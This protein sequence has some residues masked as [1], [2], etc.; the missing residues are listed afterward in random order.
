MRFVREGGWRCAPV[1][2]A[3]ADCT[4]GAPEDSHDDDYEAH[5]DIVGGEEKIKKKVGPTFGGRFG[6]PPRMEG[7]RRNL[8]GHAKWRSI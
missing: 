7:E 1:P 5:T 2:S 6:G 3:V 4:I 8:E